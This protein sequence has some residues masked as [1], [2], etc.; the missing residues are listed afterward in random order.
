MTR[1]FDDHFR[2]HAKL[3]L[4]YED[5]FERK[6]VQFRRIQEFL[7]LSKTPALA[8]PLKKQNQRNQHEMIANY[9]ELADHFAETKWASFF[10]G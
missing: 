4:Y 1:E 10:T 3:E 9:D 2:G 8:S 7:D 5:I 6:E